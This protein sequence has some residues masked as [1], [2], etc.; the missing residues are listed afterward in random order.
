M[1]W[2]ALISCYLGTIIGVLLCAT[3]T[4]VAL[5]WFDVLEVVFWPLVLLYKYITE[6]LFK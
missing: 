4:N 6:K 2:I 1:W 3:W 5:K